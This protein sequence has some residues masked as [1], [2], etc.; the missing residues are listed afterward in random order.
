VTSRADQIEKAHRIAKQL[1]QV[2]SVGDAKAVGR[3]AVRMSRR[4]IAGLQTGTPVQDLGGGPPTVIRARELDEFVA[5]SDELGGPNAPDCVTYWNRFRYQPTKQVNQSLD[6]Y[7]DEYFAEQLA[8]YEEISGR[9]LDQQTNELLDFDVDLHVQAP[10]PYNHPDPSILAGQV[11]TLASACR[12][13]GASRG[14]KV[15][16]MGC[17]WGLSSETLAYCGLEVDAVDI[18]QGFVDLVNQRANRL[19]LPIRAHAST[20]DTYEPP[21]GTEYTFSLFYECFHHATKPWEL[22]E[23]I[24]S[25][26][27]PSGKFLLATEPVQASWWT[28]WGIRLDPLS[29]YCIRKY[30]W[31]ESGWSDSFLRDMFARNGLAVSTVQVGS[32]PN[33]IYVGTP[34]EPTAE[35]DLRSVAR[36]GQWWEETVGFLVS[37]GDSSID[38]NV[39][40]HT[41]RIHL[42]V[43][44]FRLTPMEVNVFFGGRE[45]KIYVPP[46]PKLIRLPWN[47]SAGPANVRFVSPCW[48]P[49]SETGSEDT[50]SMS[51]H[52]SSI[53][54]V[55]Y[56]STTG[57]R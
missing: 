17:G 40:V 26:L 18:N 29:V 53:R 34:I 35:A 15:L 27:V 20:F 55:T 32:E 21:P 38:L 47:M 5:K 33:D 12:A 14:N 3:K 51:I 28:T 39:P 57:W 52:L 11:A 4:A 9:K 10:N 2:R 54:F 30:G 56:A 13:A 41:T 6:P 19:G 7:S 44:N 22:M 24:V 49:S 1:R 42:Q 31:F 16:D 8:L 48:S 45:Y 50:R 23:R 36:A 46:G 37:K 43:H 25:M